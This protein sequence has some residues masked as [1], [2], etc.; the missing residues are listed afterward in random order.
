MGSEKG[1]ETWAILLSL[2]YTA[3]LHHL[4]VFAYLKEVIERTCDTPVTELESFL[5][6][7]RK[8]THA[9]EASP[10]LGRTRDNPTRTSITIT[11]PKPCHAQGGGCRR[12]DTY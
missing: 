6:D 4:N 1:G 7:V 9:Y 11:L 2:L 10:P 8:K 12:P 5:P 3:K